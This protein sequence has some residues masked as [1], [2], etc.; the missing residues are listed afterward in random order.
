M[1]H[2]VSYGQLSIGS[3]PPFWPE[4]DSRVSRDRSTGRH[5]KTSNNFVGEHG[6]GRAFRVF[7]LVAIEPTSHVSTQKT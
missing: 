4:V 2:S 5:I 7:D 6:L 1:L 3:S